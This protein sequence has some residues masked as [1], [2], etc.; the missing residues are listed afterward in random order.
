MFNVNCP[1]RQPGYIIIIIRSSFLILIW[2]FKHIQSNFIYTTYQFQYI[3]LALASNNID[4]QGWFE[5][6]IATWLLIYNG[7][8]LLF[9][10][11]LPQIKSNNYP[12][13]N[14]HYNATP[15]PVMWTEKAY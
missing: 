10:N 9:L 15:W 12:W 11:I 4:V 7:S 1:D 5:N 14:V 8:T 2:V 3:L 13:V 6:N